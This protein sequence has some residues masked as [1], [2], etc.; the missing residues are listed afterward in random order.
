MTPK[1]VHFAHRRHG[2]VWRLIG[3]AGTCTVA[4][5]AG[6]LWFAT[7]LPQS[8]AEPERVTDAIVT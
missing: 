8:V 1:R 5:L 6:L 7:G 3:I 4:W 2:L